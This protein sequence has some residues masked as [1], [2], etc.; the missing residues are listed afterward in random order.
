MSVSLN[1]QGLAHLCDAK[2]DLAGRTTLRVRME[3][4]EATRAKERE[5]ER[6]MLLKLEACGRGTKRGG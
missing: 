5:D 2:T 4:R 6:I 1:V 3:G